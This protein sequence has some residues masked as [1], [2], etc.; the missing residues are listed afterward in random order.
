MKN[1]KAIINF[2]LMMFF[3][4]SI[5]YSQTIIP[6]KLESPKNL[7]SKSIEKNSVWISGQWIASDG[8]YI[9]EKGYWEKKK[10][11]YIFLPGY[12]KE[13]NDG[14]CWISGV[15]KQINLKEWNNIYS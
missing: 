11:G 6:K 9:W 3:I 1:L 13:I 8:N 5:S 10:P 4:G 14:W 2:F 15:W 7:I 12:W